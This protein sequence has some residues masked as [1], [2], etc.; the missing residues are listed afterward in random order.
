MMFWSK[1]KG[2]QPKQPTIHV[3]SGGRVYVD[4]NE[5]MATEEAQEQLTK[6]KRL[7][8]S[9]GVSNPSQSLNKQREL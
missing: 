1:K 3:T 2:G 5:L 9:L 8:D 7:L 6:M 4:S